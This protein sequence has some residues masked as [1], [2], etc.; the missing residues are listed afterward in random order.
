MPGAK[1]TF[2]KTFLTPRAYYREEITSADILGPA[3]NRIPEIRLDVQASVQMQ[4]TRWR[5]PENS[6]Y[7]DLPAGERLM[8]CASA[9]R[10]YNGHL[11]LYVWFTPSGSPGCDNAGPAIVGVLE[12]ADN[13]CHATFRVWAWGGAEDI[14]P[15]IGQLPDPTE[16][17]EELSSSSLSGDFGRWCLLHEQSVVTD[18]LIVLPDIPANRYRV[19][20]D[21]ISAECQV[22]ILEQHTE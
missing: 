21:Y 22:D 12:N 18:T 16:I 13:R 20:V 17:D 9:E 6:Q 4:Y 5:D 8:Q 19:T 1:T 14:D 10:A 2:D 11:E 3:D 15:V 7:H